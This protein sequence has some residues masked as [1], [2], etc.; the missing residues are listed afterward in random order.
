VLLP[1]ILRIGLLKGGKTNDYVPRRFTEKRGL[2]IKAATMYNTSP[3]LAKTLASSRSF[4]KISRSFSGG[5]RGNDS[6]DLATVREQ[7][8][9]L[10][11][12]TKSWKQRPTL[13]VTE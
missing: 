7:I 11:L 10:D 1:L 2:T 5:S 9:Q 3:V 13:S 6:L 4:G 8:H 12:L